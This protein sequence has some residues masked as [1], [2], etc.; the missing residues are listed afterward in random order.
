MTEYRATYKCRLCGK[1][2]ITVFVA[3]NRA[4]AAET[5]T[6]LVEGVDIDDP[7]APVMQKVHYCDNG[8]IGISDFQGW[9]LNND[10]L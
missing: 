4:L 10:K 3:T 5:A 6:A 1:E 9:R 2:I 7:L 8:G